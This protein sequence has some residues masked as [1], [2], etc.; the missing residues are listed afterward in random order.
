ME[1]YLK[2][3]LTIM[4]VTLITIVSLYFLF[5]ATRTLIS[6]LTGENGNNTAQLTNSYQRREVQEPSVAN[7]LENLLSSNNQTLPLEFTSSQEEQ[8]DNIQDKGNIQSQDPHQS[9]N[10]EQE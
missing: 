8:N 4:A 10:Q 6:H 7:A 1:E 3:L 5:L 9:G 2:A